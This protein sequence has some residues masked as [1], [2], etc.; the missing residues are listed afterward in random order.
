M[1]IKNVLQ[2]L[3]FAT[4]SHIKRSLNQILKRYNLQNA[5]NLAQILSVFLGEIN[6]D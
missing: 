5:P 1:K 3:N 4:K 2:S 6:S